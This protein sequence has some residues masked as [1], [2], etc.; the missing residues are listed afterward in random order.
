[1][2]GAEVLKSI[3]LNGLGDV[4]GKTLLHLQCHFGQD[5]LAW[6]RRGATVTGVDFSQNA[7]NLAN[8]LA[9]KLNLPAKFVCCNVY[10]VAEHVH[11]QFD[12]VFTSYGTIG[13][14]PDLEPWAQAIAKMLKPGGTFYIADFHPMVWLFDDDFTKIAYS[15]FNTE[16]IVTESVGSYVDR[17]A[18]L[19]STEYGW[20]HPF[21]DSIGALLRAGLTLESFEEFDYSPYDCFRNTVNIGEGKYQIKGMEGTLPMVFA[22]R[23]RLEP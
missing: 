14:L 10:D 19:K 1:M 23:M 13:W 22:L 16:T 4:S 3:E 20:N 9:Q 21:S 18:P 12:I 5:T 15:Y 6:A 8:S 17:E 7:V 2:N 11:E